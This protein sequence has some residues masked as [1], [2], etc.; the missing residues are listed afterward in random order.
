[1][2][3]CELKSS[4]V[5]MASSRRPD[6]LHTG[7]LSQKQNKSQVKVLRGEDEGLY[8]QGAAETA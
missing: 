1:M 7:N 6:L 5:Y 8:Q 2:E 3:L 4:L